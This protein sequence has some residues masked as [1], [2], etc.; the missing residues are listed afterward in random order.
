MT[1]GTDTTIGISASAI[2]G[3]GLTAQAI[4]EGLNL[5]L[6]GL[7][8]ILVAGGLVLVGYR[9]VAIIRAA[10]RKTRNQR[11]DDPKE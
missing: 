3:T 4:T 9:I 6:L 7:N 11:R 2:G 10:K 5:V 1:R 8:I